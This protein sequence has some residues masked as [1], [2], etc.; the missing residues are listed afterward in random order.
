MKISQ[1]I[2]GQRSSSSVSNGGEK[3]NWKKTG[4]GEGI[5]Q[6]SYILL[7]YIIS[8]QQQLPEMCYFIFH[9]WKM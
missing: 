9:Y 5:E 7:S 1:C 4:R 3:S 8:K 2:L 6:E